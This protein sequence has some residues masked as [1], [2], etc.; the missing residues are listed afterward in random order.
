MDNIRILA[1]KINRPPKKDKYKILTFPTHE[2]YQTLLDKTGH[3][4]YMLSLEGRKMWETKYRPV[5]ENHEIIPTIYD[6]LSDIDFILSHER[7]G[8]LQTA[9][10]ISQQSRLPIVHMEHIEP[11]DDR[12]TKEQGD[13]LRGITGDINVFIT[14][15][16]MGTW[17]FS[18]IGQVVPHGI[19]TETFSGWTGSNK[20]YV[21]YS[22]NRLEERDYFCGHKQWQ[23][24]KS[25]V[26]SQMPDVE[27]RLVGDNP[28][29][30]RPISDVKELVSQYNNCSCYINTSQ[31]SP[32][33]MTVLEAMSCGCP[34]VSSSKQEI[35]KV[36]DGSNGFCSNNTKEMADKIL[37]VLTDKNL[38]SSM[39]AA[40]RKTVEDRFS[41][42]T[43][44]SNWND[45]F[46]TAYNMRLGKG[47]INE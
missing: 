27:F 13:S 34:V 44:V 32:I 9:L 29:I 24:V 25:I 20:K 19:D 33:P 39:G 17:G 37:E 47:K 28:G 7:F 6:E 38:A 2:G 43:F 45:V 30:S 1:S 26:Q 21:L 41:L 11:Q 12:W 8:Q 5:P 42:D 23:E 3:T 16:N 18:D 22:V 46:D 31:L 15:H 4:F 14:Q 35:P 10:D 40:A 36:L